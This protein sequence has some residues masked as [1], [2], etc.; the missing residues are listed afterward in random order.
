MVMFVVMATPFG[1]NQY[2]GYTHAH[3]NGFEFN[4][5]QRKLADQLLSVF[6]NNTTDIQYEY[7]E[8]LGDGRGITAGRA[9]FTS[10]T[11]DMH[12]VVKKYTELMP[13]NP[14][15]PYNKQLSR[16]AREWSGST[17]GLK[18]LPKAWRTAA[19]DP[20]F[21]AVQDAVVNQLYYDRAVVYANEYGLN[22]PVS[23]LVLYDTIVQH[24]YG[25]DADGL[26]AMLKKTTRTL[27]GSPH[28]EI[29]ERNWLRALLDCRKQVLQSPSN[30]KTRE[31]WRQSVPRVDVLIEILDSGNLSLSEPF[32]V[33]PW[34]T[35]FTLYP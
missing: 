31:V 1:G 32:T 16:L 33:N 24:G 4:L 30:W 21:R 13:G 14:L 3:D 8:V 5:S 26:P 23:L 29:D 15:A 35:A 6:E 9:G 34:G 22:E 25:D 2:I 20:T 18:G 17:R 10:A 28:N 11:G 7:A 12:L 19:Q 27:G